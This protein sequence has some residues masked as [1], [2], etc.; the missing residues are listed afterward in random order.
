M[1]GPGFFPSD[2]QDLSNKEVFARLTHE[3]RAPKPLNGRDR[4][5]PTLFGRIWPMLFDR[6]WP[7]RIWQIF[8]GGGPDGVGARGACYL[9]QMSLRPAIFVT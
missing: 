1:E 9:G 6:I 4:I 5:W 8:F 3:S 2:N 7:D